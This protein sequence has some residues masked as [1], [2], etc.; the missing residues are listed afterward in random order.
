MQLPEP[1]PSRWKLLGLNGT[2]IKVGLKERTNWLG[3]PSKKEEAPTQF[4]FTIRSLYKHL[5]I[6][7]SDNNMRS[8]FSKSYLEES[9]L[10]TLKQIALWG[11][12]L[13]L[14]GII[15]YT[16]DDV[17]LCMIFGM[18]PVG[19]IIRKVEERTVLKSLNQRLYGL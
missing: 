5:G 12:I 9:I 15:G 16:I 4:P 18:G 10:Q 17:F 13:V 1:Y 7:L 14:L 8:I 11:V 6:E 3:N 2:N 19:V